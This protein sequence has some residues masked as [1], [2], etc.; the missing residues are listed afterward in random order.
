MRELPMGTFLFVGFV[1]ATVAWWQWR[2]G[3]GYVVRRVTARRNARG[4]R[5]F[6]PPQ[7]PQ[8]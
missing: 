2:F 7:R 3:F 5:A 4:S 1:I 6:K 8:V